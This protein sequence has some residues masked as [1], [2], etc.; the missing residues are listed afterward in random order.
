MKGNDFPLL[1]HYDSTVTTTILV[2]ATI[3]VGAMPGAS[4]FETILVIGHDA[5]HSQFLK[6][7]LF[8]VH[9]LS[10]SKIQALEDEG[11]R[12]PF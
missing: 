5:F 1:I 12:F 3:G 10:P 9:G 2:I 4:T 6:L 8:D 7:Q 11:E